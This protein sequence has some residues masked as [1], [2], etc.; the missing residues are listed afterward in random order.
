MNDATFATPVS[1]ESLQSPLP[2][3][4]LQF[5]QSTG[6]MAGRASCLVTWERHVFNVVGA[7]HVRFVPAGQRKSVVV[8]DGST[9]ELL[10]ILA[11]IL[12]WVNSSSARKYASLN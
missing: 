8:D 11:S 5:Q 10:L 7:L 9:M 1:I 6:W 2:C 12:A 3:P 4:R